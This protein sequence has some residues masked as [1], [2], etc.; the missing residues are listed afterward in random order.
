MTATSQSSTWMSHALFL[1][2]ALLLSCAF[3]LHA[4]AAEVR[5]IGH[6]YLPQ[7]PEW[8]ARRWPSGV[9]PDKDTCTSGFIFGPIQAGDYEKVRDLYRKNHPFIADFTIASPGGNVAEAIKIGQLFRQYLIQANAP[10]RIALSK[11]EPFFVSIPSDLPEC[12]ELNSCVCASACALIWFG[13]VDRFGSAG[14]HRPRTDDPSFKA[15]DATKATQAYRETLNSVRQYMDT[16]EVPKPLIETMI[17]TGSADI[18]WV[19]G[20]DDG[21]ERPPSLAEWEDATCGRLTSEEKKV[22]RKN[23]KS[24]TPEELNLK[25]QLE[26]RD[27]KR[28]TCKIVLLSRNRDKLSPP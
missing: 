23:T 13:A 17:A 6:F 16:M 21:L 24:M 12:Q 3:S 14:L 28:I 25:S 27:K 18:K 5:C 26:I 22:L 4:R 15:L 11:E 7:K 1:L 19:D 10:L 9:R 20:V 8:F 2:F